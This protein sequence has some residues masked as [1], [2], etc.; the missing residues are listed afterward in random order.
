MNAP[1]RPVR[2]EAEPA[3]SF[4]AWRL[5]GTAPNYNAYPIAIPA[6]IDDAERAAQHALLHHKEVVAVVRTDHA[7]RPE[8]RH[9]LSLYLVKRR[10]NP[11]YERINGK[12]RL[13]PAEYPDLISCA[14]VPTDSPFIEP[15]DAMADPVGVDRTLIEQRS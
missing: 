1:I 4:K 14:F 13:K 2:M 3:V 6:D 7:K 9:L 12:M 8:Q 10:S 15:H 5:V 11:G